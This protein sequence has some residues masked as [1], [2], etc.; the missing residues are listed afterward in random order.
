MSRNTVDITDLAKLNK[1]L[2]E[3]ERSVQDKVLYSSL[4]KGAKVL[5]DATESQLI[6]KMGDSA[7]RPIRKKSGKGWY[8]P[9]IDGVRMG[10]D[11]GYCEVNVNILGQGY[12]RWFE[13]GTNIR[14]TSKGYN[15]GQISALN[16]FLA[17]KNSTDVIGTILRNIERQ[18]NKLN[19]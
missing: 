19:N 8:K 11:K 10:G 15:R 16:F 9:L 2:S 1:D 5:K 7:T 17:A 12:L 14:K 6:A 13:K 4:I 3:F 18:I